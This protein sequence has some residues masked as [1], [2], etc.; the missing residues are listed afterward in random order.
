MNNK[1]FPKKITPLISYRRRY[2]FF[3]IIELVIHNLS[4]TYFGNTILNNSF[5]IMINYFLW[6]TISYIFE[7]YSN[8]NPK[9]I[10]EFIKISVLLIIFNF[11]NA[12]IQNIFSTE[13]IDYTR[14]INLNLI[15]CTTSFLFI[16]FYRYANAK[17]NNMH[18]KWIFI[19]TDNKNLEL[20][21][22]EIQEFNK[23]IC[24]E[25][26]ELNSIDLPRLRGIIT[27]TDLERNLIIKKLS[28]RNLSLNI[29]VILLKDWCQFY[30]QRIPLN[31]IN[32]ERI[33]NIEKYISSRYTKIQ[34][35]FKNNIEF[36]FA[37]FLLI[38]SS[39]IILISAVLIYFEDKGPIFYKQKRVGIN[40]KIFNIYKIRSMKKNAENNGPQWA[41][42]NDS[43]ITTIGALI[44]KTR[45]DEL[46][47]LLCILNGNMSLIGPRPERPEFVEL[48]DKE[49][50]Y[51]S[52]RKL[53]K[54]GLTGWAQVNYPYGASIKDSKTK[55]TFDLFYIE[56][57]SIL[58]DFL[59][60]FKTIKLVLQAK[61][62]IPNKPI[63]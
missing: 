42:K 27:N 16:Y 25:I 50:K 13:N 12:L 54:P 58:L 38:F 35:F 56:N 31:M 20:P 49:T 9:F 48:I 40:G 17:N 62:A 63:E 26:N 4:L 24:Y 37:F 30:L 55:L 44:R 33:N 36:I 57:I 47:Q 29:P 5:Y 34:I 15:I 52:M 8:K 51:Y 6:F 14:I 21:I 23:I 7:R 39:P 10:N 3:I 19:A 22:S 59:I 11:F 46:P 45:I 32:K 18:K 53:V 43:R 41:K 1:N 28:Q 60:F 2:L 61:G